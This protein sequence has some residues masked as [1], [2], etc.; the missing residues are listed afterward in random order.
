MKLRLIV[1]TTLSLLWFGCTPNQT[2]Y[3]KA[4]SFFPAEFVDHFPSIWENGYL[5][6]SSL[7]KNHEGWEYYDYTFMPKTV[8]AS[9]EFLRKKKFKEKS[10]VIKDNAKEVYTSTDSL[11]LFVCYYSDMTK[12]YAGYKGGLDARSEVNKRYVT[13]NLS[14]ETGRPVVLFDSDWK[15]GGNTLGG[16]DESFV[17]YILDAKPGKFLPDEYLNEPEVSV[18]P[19]EWI[20][21]FTKGAAISEKL[22]TIIYWIAVW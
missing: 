5:S 6:Q 19:P 20:H 4:L 11:L 12:K 14:I 18:M 3:R 10:K 8:Y 7:S 22:K 13:R 21:G 16:L 9:V 2:D 1:L 17:Y 15:Y